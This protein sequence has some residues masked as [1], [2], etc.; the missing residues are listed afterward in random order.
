[1]WLD[2][3]HW[4]TSAL[5]SFREWSVV[6]VWL[7]IWAQPRNPCQPRNYASASTW[8][9]DEN[10]GFH[11]LEPSKPHCHIITY[12]QD[13]GLIFWC[14]IA[15][16]VINEILKIHDNIKEIIAGVKYSL[17]YTYITGQWPTEWTLWLVN[18]L[19][20][21]AAMCWL[22]SVSKCKHWRPAVYFLH[23]NVKVSVAS[24]AQIHQVF[25]C[26]GKSQPTVT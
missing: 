10:N 26:N 7:W 4:R 17:I 2:L 9:R 25:R 24:H 13:I 21:L 15:T 14:V 18:E 11:L 1:M 16:R 8:L 19:L 20:S 22:R 5:A 12:V 6:S 3:L 23:Q